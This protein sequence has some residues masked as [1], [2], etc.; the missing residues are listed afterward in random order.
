MTATA[1]SSEFT[2]VV[3]P[4]HP[5]PQLRRAVY[6]IG[7]F[8]G[9]HLGHRAVIE[10]TLE[11]ARAK[12][13]PAAVLTFEPHPADYFA[14]RPVVFRLTPFAE[15]ARALQSTGLD[16]A[17][18]LSFDA[19]LAGLSAEIFIEQVLIERLGIGAAVIG[20][21]FHFGK[22][23]SGSPAFLAATGERLGFD[24]VILTKI[25]TTH[26]AQAEVISS[27]STRRAL[28]CGDVDG[29]ATRLGRPYEV[30]GVVVTGKKLGRELG[31]PTANVALPATNRLAYGVYAVRAVFD[32][33]P[34]DA[35]AS[36]GVRPTVNGVEPLLETFIFDFSGD[37]YGKEIAVQFFAHLRGEE[38]FNSLDALKAAMQ[39]DMARARSAL[40]ERPFGVWPQIL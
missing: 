12:G 28:E 21:D 1:A 9:V 15:K 11:I 13:L 20:A 34:H 33:K 32:G 30:S 5:S 17:V 35:V 22:D 4:S 38:K 24:V 26:N 25:E 36:F 7:N 2:L 23:R 27:S 8:D 10:R 14:G 6:A 19:S 29:A 16:G 3:D 18:A 31:V 37:L 40:A 39:N